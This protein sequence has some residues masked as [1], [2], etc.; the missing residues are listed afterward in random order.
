[1]KYLII[2]IFMAALLS[3]T[4]TYAQDLPDDNEMIVNISKEIV[5]NMKKLKFEEIIKYCYPGSEI[6]KLTKKQAAEFES[7]KDETLALEIKQSTIC[8]LNNVFDIG[9][10]KGIIICKKYKEEK[11][12]YFLWIFRKHQDTWFLF[13]FEDLAEKKL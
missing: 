7:E 8:Y 13:S 9:K 2:T 11:K 1:M 5:V 3:A 10:D 6:E 12:E 4:G